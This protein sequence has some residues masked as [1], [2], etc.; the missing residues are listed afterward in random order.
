MAHQV[1]MAALVEAVPVETPT[2]T[3]THATS[4]TASST[5]AVAPTVMAVVD[6]VTDPAGATPALTPYLFQQA[7][8]QLLPDD[9]RLVSRLPSGETIYRKRLIL[10]MYQDNDQNPL[11]TPISVQS[12]SDALSV[13]SEDG[14]NPSEYQFDAIKPYLNNPNLKPQTSEEA[15]KIDILLTEAYLRA[16]YNLD[17][18]KVDPERLDADNNYATE[19]N[20]LERSPL[21][22][23]W[24][25]KGRIDQAF[26]WVRPKSD[27][28]KSLKAAL[29]RY[30]RIMA[31]GGWP[32]IP[33]GN[34]I[35]PGNS[36]SRIPLIRTRLA[37]TGDLATAS[38]SDVF[39]TEL[40]QAIKK[41]QDRHD[42]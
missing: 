6:N 33:G 2:P 16:L 37:M 24:V 12:L 25:Q 4:E 30:Q 35:K 36:D 5:E 18:G 34:I 7:V 3:E 8:K 27:R 39:D 28:Y 23:S 15:A 10:K 22:L 1:S 29:I 42:M 21:F 38:G 17:Y 32:V 11:W 14:L 31:A 26:A 41:F 13:L 20:D 40:E 9:D 19:H